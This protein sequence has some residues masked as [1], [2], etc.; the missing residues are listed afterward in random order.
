[1]AV[2][3]RLLEPED[4]WIIKADIKVLFKVRSK[5]EVRIIVYVEEV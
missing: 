3:L 2:L 1:M 4:S 5:L